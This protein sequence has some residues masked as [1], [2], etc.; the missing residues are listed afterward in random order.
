MEMRNAKIE[1]SVQRIRTPWHLWF[2]GL[3]FIF[4]YTNGIYDYFMMRGHNEA[5]YSAKNYGEA[6]FVYFTNYPMLPLIFWTIN[7]F[8]GLIAPILLLIRSRLAV[9]VS[10]ISSVSI[11]CQEFIT[12]AFMDRW[13]TLGPWISLFDIGILITTFGLFIYCRSMNKRGVLR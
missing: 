9:Q 6:V 13:N 11:L 1:T 12:F 3:F 4:L 8:S 5:Y 2:I 7:V 10:L